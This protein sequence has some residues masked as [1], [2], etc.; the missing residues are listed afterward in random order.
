MF[1]TGLRVARDRMSDEGKT[2][3]NVG[4]FCSSGV[5]VGVLRGIGRCGL[6]V[7]ADNKYLT[8]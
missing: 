3:R 5:G 6:D 8:E 1:N 4:S 2:E 7:N